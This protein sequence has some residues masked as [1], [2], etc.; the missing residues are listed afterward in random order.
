MNNYYSYENTIL[1]AASRAR[2]DKLSRL[3]AIC[4]SQKTIS[5]LK[6]SREIDLVLEDE[7]L[8]AI[9]LKYIADKMAKLQAE[10]AELKKKGLWI[11]KK[12]RPVNDHLE[13]QC[14]E[15]AIAINFNSSEPYAFEIQW[16]DDIWCSIG[17]EEFTHWMPQPPKPKGE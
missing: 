16:E 10:N 8:D 7:K 15:T 4:E 6:L 12:E 17:G 2:G 1:I 9:Y 11:C 13:W 3:Y 5:T 14:G